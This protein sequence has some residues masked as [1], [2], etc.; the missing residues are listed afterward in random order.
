MFGSGG[1]AGSS[2]PGTRKSSSRRTVSCPFYKK[3]THAVSVVA[4]LTDLL[5]DKVTF[6]WSPVCQQAFE[7]IKEMLCGAPVLAAP[8]FDRPFSLQVDASHVGAGAALVQVDDLGVERPV[9]FFSKKFNSYQLNYSTIEKEA[10]TLIWALKH[11]A[12]YVD[13]GVAPAC[14]GLHGSQSLDVFQLS[15]VSQPKIDKMVLVAAI[16]LVRY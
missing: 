7:K 3:G 8:Q 6:V 5:K 10:L 14:G 16:L 15:A 13:S 9:S 12:V 4:P 11:F 2:S 1:R